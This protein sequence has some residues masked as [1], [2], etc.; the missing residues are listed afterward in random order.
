VRHLTLAFGPNIEGLRFPKPSRFEISG[1][2]LT[3][4][5]LPRSIQLELELAHP[6]FWFFSTFI[7]RTVVESFVLSTI[8]VWTGMPPWST[9]S[10]MYL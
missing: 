8:F 9:Q 5:V 3:F 1:R 7:K 4:Y 6:K 10:S 2:T